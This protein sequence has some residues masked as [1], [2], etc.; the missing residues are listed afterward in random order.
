MYLGMTVEEAK[1][2]LMW[3]ALG[4]SYG[5]LPAHKYNDAVQCL[6][7]HSLSWNLTRSMAAA[8]RNERA[9]WHLENIRAVE[10]TIEEQIKHDVQRSEENITLDLFG[11][12]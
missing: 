8:P 3:A 2:I 4:A 11:G 1:A 9:Q 6:I 7:D 10:L 5:E 12:Q